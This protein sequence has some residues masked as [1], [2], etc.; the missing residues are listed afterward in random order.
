MA[1]AKDQIICHVCGFKN[2]PDAPRCVSCGAKLDA[3]QVE[4]SAEEE[5]ARENQQEGFS[6]LWVLVAFGIYLTLQAIVLVLLPMAISSYDPIGV[7]GLAISIVVWFFGGIIV[8]YLS[9]GKTF[10]EPAAGASLACV[11][12]IAY[13]HYVTP[14]GVMQAGL[15]EVLVLA[16]MG[17]M[18]SLFGAFLGERL[19]ARTRGHGKPKKR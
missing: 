17:I 5:A 14:D 6:V 7:A 16:V 13:N 8:G 11:P 18:I 2:A 9:P 4:Y 15:M 3:V 12:T 19:Q 10:L 1:S